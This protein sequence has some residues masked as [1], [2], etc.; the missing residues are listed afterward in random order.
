ME[1]RRWSAGLLAL[2]VL[3]GCGK[4]SYK[5]PVANLKDSKLVAEPTKEEKHGWWCAEHGIPEAECSMCNA[6]VAEAFKKKGDWCKA[7]DR[8]ESQ[9]FIC[10]PNLKEKYAAIYRAK[11]GKEPPPIEEE[12]DA[13]KGEK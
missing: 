10:N 13:P 8:A 1:L 6:K 5:A 3:A 7:H 4:P 9:C 11:Y 12:K 2:V